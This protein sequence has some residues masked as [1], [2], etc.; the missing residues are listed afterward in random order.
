MAIPLIDYGANADRNIRTARGLADDLTSAATTYRQHSDQ[1]DAEQKQEAEKNRP[2][3]QQLQDI[4]NYYHTKVANKEMPGAVAAAHINAVAAGLEPATLGATPSSPGAPDSGPASSAGPS[5]VG[6]F[7]GTSAPTGGQIDD[8]AGARTVDA[9]SLG[10]INTPPPPAAGAHGIT[11]HGG[12]LHVHH[13]AS[14]LG[15]T[16]AQPP[17]TP[18]PEASTVFSQPAPRAPD[19]LRQRDLP[20]LHAAMPLFQEKSQRDYMA[21]TDAKNR[22][23]LER[24]RLANEGT[25]NV[26]GINAKAK[27]ETNTATNTSREAVADTGAGSREKVAKVA[28]EAKVLAARISAAATA[29]KALKDTEVKDITSQVNSLQSELGRLASSPPFPGRDEEI[30]NARESLDRVIPQLEAAKAKVRA[31]PKGGAST[32]SVRSSGPVVTGGQP[33]KLSPQDVSNLFN[34]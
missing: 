2:L 33:T 8:A 14:S 29:G 9:T 20:A 21:E 3:P 34:K 12:N 24:Q 26:A 1:A 10:D 28:A 27:V 16:P 11:M 19:V 30:K 32:S 18:P 4:V 7:P 23:L 25:G 5:V 22:A 15:D 31:A 6:N 13:Y 17:L